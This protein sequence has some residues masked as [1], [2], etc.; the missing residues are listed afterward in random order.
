MIIYVV[1]Q[2]DTL[3]T[4]SQRFG[5]SWEA[6]AKQN[7]LTHPEELVVGQ[8]IVILTDVITYAIQPGDRLTTIANQ[9]NIPVADIILAN[10]KL[11][12]PNSLKA[13]DTIT[14]PLPN[15]N[16]GS[17]KV[18]GFVFPNT[19]NE[20]LDLT[21][22]DLTYVS[23]F[24]YQVRP[25][26]SLMNIPDENVIQKAKQYNVAPLMTITN[27]E[28]DGGFS[29]EITNMLF[30]SAQARQALIQNILNTMAAKGYYGLVVDFEYVFPRDRDNFT[31]FMR[32]LTDALH[33]E[34]YLVMSALA[35]KISADMVGTLYEAH[36]YGAHAQI[37]DYIIL[38]TY[39]WGYTFGPPRAVAPL[40]NVKEVLD[41]AVTVIP[42]SK[43]LMGMPNYGYDWRLPY[44][45]GTA[46]RNVTN[47]G[48]VDL[49]R[50][51][52]SFIQYDTRSQAPYFNYWEPTN[53]HVVWFEDARSIDAKLRLVNQYGLAGVS[54]WNLNKYFPQNW[55]VLTQL[56][57][58]TKVI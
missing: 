34:N 47:T 13:G 50:Q 37:V 38:M 16:L 9:F 26:G 4:I 53:E 14:I 44:Q 28:E 11:A 39:E 42:R 5:V 49:A 15:E 43:I 2:G 54:Y 55:L 8:T 18:N 24:S 23:I 41:Y 58:V 32:E 17:M 31:A 35:P 3:Y 29:G 1:K 36:D 27:I 22:P 20:V 56:Y 30:A 19:S 6:V 57:N 10:P 21:L 52:G 46:A 12:I 7:M 48:A 25:D 33:A 51:E 40:N 45:P